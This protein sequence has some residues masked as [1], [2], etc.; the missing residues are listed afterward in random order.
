M[1]GHLLMSSKERERLKVLARV[2]RGELKLSGFWSH[3]GGG[4]AGG[5]WL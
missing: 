1:E 3:P 4:E 2:K 5:R